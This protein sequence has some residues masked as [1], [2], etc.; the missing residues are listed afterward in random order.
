MDATF[1]AGLSLDRHENRSMS[2]NF[3]VN[4]CLKKMSGNL[5]YKDLETNSNRKTV[6]N[7]NFSMRIYCELN[8]NSIFKF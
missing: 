4:S 5:V 3:E 1:C 8:P 7:L 6:H 2:P